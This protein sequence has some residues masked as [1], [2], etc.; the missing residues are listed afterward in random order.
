[1]SSA[2]TPSRAHDDAP[3]MYS[4]SPELSTPPKSESDSAA[5]SPTPTTQPHA[6]AAAFS[7]N[8]TISPRFDGVE[9]ARGFSVGKHDNN[10]PAKT[11]NAAPSA[12]KSV[13]RKDVHA[14]NGV[15][16]TTDG[17]APKH[18]TA[19]AKH[20]T[21][22]SSTQPRK[23]L[24]S[25]EPPEEKSYSHVPSRQAKL[26]DLVGSQNGSTPSA[27][28]PLSLELATSQSG[29]GEAIRDAKQRPHP[30]QVT[31]VPVRSSGQNYDPIRS[32]TIEST[33]QPSAFSGG[34]TSPPPPKSAN[35]ASASPSISSLIDPPMLNAALPSH[36]VSQSARLQSASASNSTP[37][38]PSTIH[39]AQGPAPVSV[40]HIPGAG[41]GDDDERG[42]LTPSS[43]ATTGGAA[44]KKVPIGTNTGN[45][46]A[47]H[48]PKPARQKEGPPP[49][50][51][52][53]GLLSSALFGGPT[54]APNEDTDDNTRPATIILD[55]P[56]KGET[57]K[58]VNFT[59]LAEQRYGFNALHPRIAAQR[60]RLAR[61][62]AAGAALEN[63]SGSADDM[64][65]DLSDPE[66]NVEMGGTDGNENEVK[67]RKRKPKGDDYDKDDPF[68]DDSE[69]VWE[70]H[71]AKAKDGFFVYSGPL[72]P[73]GEAP[74]IE[75]ADGT[76]PKRGRGR[77][78]GSRGG[79]TRGSDT[80]RGGSALGSTTS[81]RGAASAGVTSTRGSTIV[82]KPRI[83]KADRARME[84]EKLER[85]RMATLAAKPS[86]Y[87]E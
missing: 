81:T 38:S 37:S 44:S 59:Q 15:T 46:S 33:P 41:V 12:K 58:F 9:E 83:R 11:S 71:A 1:M 85:E 27:H 86:T 82:R 31:T 74:A 39:V 23:K 70:Q 79:S 68:V 55:I 21:N 63:G 32:A 25:S 40:P 54:S 77:G 87:V 56:M 50:P 3:A 76:V 73:A 6:N 72:V 57:N 36:P 5:P 7:H 48:S 35:R 14:Q 26:T 43:L 51:Q 20:Q 61:V 53:S 62:A 10:D 84:Q 29:N 34:P 28:N 60:E 69:M 19:S 42:R 49:A 65:V 8:S 30:A 64:S 80:G 2:V 17:K 16:T 22:A 52:G 18:K 13:R 4:S 66:S 47:A 67:K 45:S 24:K 75:R 78:R